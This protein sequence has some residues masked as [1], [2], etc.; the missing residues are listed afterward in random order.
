MFIPKECGACGP[1]SWMD[2][3]T[4]VVVPL[5][6]VVLVVWQVGGGFDSV[7][8]RACYSRQAI[9]LV[10]FP[11]PLPSAS[12]DPSSALVWWCAC[13]LVRLPQSTPRCP[14]PFPFPFPC[15]FPFLVPVVVRACCQVPV[16]SCWPSSC[17]SSCSIL[18]RTACA[19]IRMFPAKT[20]PSPISDFLNL[21]RRPFL[22]FPVCLL[23]FHPPPHH[24]SLVFFTP[25]HQPRLAQHTLHPEIPIRRRATIRWICFRWSFRRI[26]L[27]SP[28]IRICSVA[29]GDYRPAVVDFEGIHTID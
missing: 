6:L 14:F 12:P 23:L 11:L 18:Q 13:R 1:M 2:P 7:V 15:P 19:Q 17:S 20:Q 3:G 29:T 9:E 4:Q 10:A 28:A 22:P 8:M 26:P 25:F 16:S 27:V 21:A 5:C 24:P